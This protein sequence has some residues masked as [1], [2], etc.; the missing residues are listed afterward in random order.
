MATVT[1]TLVRQR[2]VAQPH[3]HPHLL[4]TTTPVL[5]NGRIITRVPTSSPPFTLADIRRAIPAYC[6]QKN[7]ITSFGYLVYD[8]TIIISLMY[9]ATHITSVASEQT[10]GSTLA[11]LLQ[12]I[13]WICYWVCQGSV[14]TG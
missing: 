6:F 3:P 7:L 1:Q 5:V 13:L 11:P 4:P 14:M 9:I 2:V 10:F 12:H 8:I